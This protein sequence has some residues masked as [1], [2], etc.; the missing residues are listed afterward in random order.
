MERWICKIKMKNNLENK[1]D[2]SEIPKDVIW[3]CEILSKNNFDSYLVGG[4]VRDLIIGREPKD[5]DITTNAMPEE[6]IKIFGEDDTVYENIFGTVGVKIRK[7]ILN[8]ESQEIE[9]VKIIE[10]T[11]YRK[12]GEY[13]DFRRPSKVEWGK[14]IEEDLERRDFTMNAFAY[15]PIKNNF[16]DIFNGIKDIE[17][18]IINT[19]GEAEKRFNEDALRMMRAVRFSSELDFV[20]DGETFNAMFKLAD[21]LSKISKERIRD[22]FI[23]IINSNGAMQAIIILQKL[24]MLK[25]ISKDLADSVGVEQNGHHTYDVFEHLLRSLNHAVEKNYDL[26]TRIAALFHDIGKPATRRYDKVKKDY[27]FYGH[28]VVGAR[29]VKK[30]L[31]DLKFEK[32]IIDKVETLVRWHMFFSDTAEITLASVRRLIVNVDKENIWDLINIRICD[33]IG[34]GTKKEEPYR[35]RK[36]ESMIDEALRDPVSLKT[37]KINGERIMMEL[38]IKPGKKVGLILNALFEEVIDEGGKNNEG[39]LVERAR[40]LNSLEEKELIELANK[41]KEKMEEKNEEEL[42]EIKK[43]FKV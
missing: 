23:K 33:R 6:I 14:T 5:W 13:E 3:V 27:T 1:I 4:C 36:F 11:T 18:K 32:K 9:N 30:I 7:N 29:M 15:D 17:N 19:V 39:Y 40:E 2:I 37:L 12:E 42:E 41:G 28:E 31:G 20:I 25:Y 34:S 43:K 21:N 38:N 10:I 26:D 35:L 24:G 8:E 16:I 22:E